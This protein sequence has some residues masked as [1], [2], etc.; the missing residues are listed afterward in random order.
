MLP[1]GTSKLD[2]AI[3]LCVI[4]LI[5]EYYRAIGNFIAGQNPGGGF[6]GGHGQYSH[7]ATTYASIL[8]MAMLGERALDVVDRRSMY[9]CPILLP[10]SASLTLEQVAV[11]RKAEAG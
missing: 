3:V 9:S 8:S 4:V 7:L 10:V 11:A 5:H 1:L 6:G 2:R